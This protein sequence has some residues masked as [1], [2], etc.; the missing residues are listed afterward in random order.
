[1]K[2]TIN[3]ARMVLY[4]AWLV[5]KFTLKT[6]RYFVKDVIVNNDEYSKLSVEERR[7]MYGKRM[8]VWSQYTACVEINKIIDKCKKLGVY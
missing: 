7:M 3:K 6:I 8:Q 1:M 2:K 5:C 4:K